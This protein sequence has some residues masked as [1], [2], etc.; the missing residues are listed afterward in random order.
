MFR[1]GTGETELHG[2]GIPK[3]DITALWRRYGIR[4]LALF[5][6]ILREDFG[7]AG[8][9]DILVEFEPGGTPGFGFIE[10]E[11]TLSRSLGHSADLHTPETLSRYFR[12]TVLKGARPPYDA[13]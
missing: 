13:A 10:L 4:R 2:I 5:G 3:E 6:S 7:P 8:D 1:R 12:E 11:D 9:I